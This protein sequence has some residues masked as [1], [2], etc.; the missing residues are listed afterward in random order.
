MTDPNDGTEYHQL[1]NPP[2]TREIKERCV[3]R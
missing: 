1:Y 3:Q 2:Q